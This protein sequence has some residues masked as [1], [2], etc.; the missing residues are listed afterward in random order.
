MGDRPSDLHTLNEGS[1]REFI[2]ITQVLFD[3]IYSP[4]GDL[5][6]SQQDNKEKRQAPPQVSSGPN[7]YCHH[8]QCYFPFHNGL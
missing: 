3:E 5:L 8:I 6:R 1:F 7:R 4:P 2:S